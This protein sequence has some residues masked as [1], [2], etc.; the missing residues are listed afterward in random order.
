MKAMIFAAGLGTRLRPFTDERPKALVEVNGVSL[1]EIAIGRLR[2]AGV[3]EIIVNIHHFGSQI[4][5]FL[6]ANCF[7]GVRVEISD[8]REMLLDTG[9]GLKRAAWFFD[10]GAPFFAYNADVLTTLDLQSMYLAHEM[11]GALATL[12]VRARDSSR[13]FLFDDAGRLSGWRNTASHVELI[14]RDVGPLH[15]LGFSGIHVI[16]PEIFGFMPEEK[17]FSIVDL[18]LDVAAQASIMAYQHDKDL[19]IDVGKPGM[20]AEA[21][22]LWK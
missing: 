14:V 18:Y 8:E 3:K 21:R 15:P 2:D 4:E 17:I 13:A 20:L 16:S 19:W 12:A 11:S 22:M 7:F 10:D 6:S 1:L 5:E 9:G